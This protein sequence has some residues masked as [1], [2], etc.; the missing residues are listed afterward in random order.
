MNPTLGSC[1]FS[2]RDFAFY[3]LDRWTGPVN[4]YVILFEIL[5]CQALSSSH[6]APYHNLKK[7]PPSVKCAYRHACLHHAPCHLEVRVIPWSAV[8]QPREGIKDKRTCLPVVVAQLL[9]HSN[10]SQCHHGQPGHPHDHNFP[11]HEIRSMPRMRQEASGPILGTLGSRINAMQCTCVPEL[12]HVRPEPPD[13]VRLGSS[14]RLFPIDKL[15]P[16]F[17][18]KSTF[19]NWS[20]RDD[21]PSLPRSLHDIKGAANAAADTQ[22]VCGVIPGAGGTAGTAIRCLAAD[23]A[24]GGAKEREWR[25]RVPSTRVA[26][27]P[28]AHC[29]AAPF[30]LTLDLGRAREALTPIMH[31]TAAHSRELCRRLVDLLHRLWHR[32]CSCP[33]CCSR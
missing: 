29:I 25:Q 28:L 21:A 1:V 23:H 16:V 17:G 2:E 6:A 14:L 19:R 18:K 9:S 3:C 33:W 10:M 7:S 24:A 15:P 11:G 32:C 4:L 26:R 20:S 27:M 8:S 13:S 31:C 5:S 30:H 22:N 12:E